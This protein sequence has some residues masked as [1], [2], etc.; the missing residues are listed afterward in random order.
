MKRKG[1][2]CLEWPTPCRYWGDPHV[3]EFLDKYKMTKARLHGCAYG[4]ENS[5][6][7]YVKTPWG[8]ASSSSMMAE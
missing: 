6:G 3:K 7:Q 8:I 1:Q 4:L 2:I 5:K